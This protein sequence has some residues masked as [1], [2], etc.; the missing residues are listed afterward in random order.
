MKPRNRNHIARLE[1]ELLEGR[2][3]PSQLT[4]APS[5]VGH[6]IPSDSYIN[7]LPRTGGVAIQVG[8][9]LEIGV[10]PAGSALPRTPFLGITKI[11]EDGRGD[12]S[13]SWDGGPVHQFSGV[14][15]ITVV[16]DAPVNDVFLE[17]TAPLQSP[18][19]IGL[20]M[21]GVA[22][23]F[24]ALLPSDSA[25]LTVQATPGV[26]TLVLSDTPVNEVFFEALEATAPLQWPEQIGL[27]MTGVIN[28]F[29]ALLPS[30][31]A[32]LTDQAAPGVFTLV[33]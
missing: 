10:A 11:V 31:S 32:P 23:A 33:L 28:P 12:V 22:N 16:G 2:L 13:V 27:N 8:S 30:G 7:R 17:A 9:I 19:Q 3:V 20:K 29:V 4:V 15:T 14:S 26:F 24:V 25:P 5:A 1:V 6:V 18:E 21:T